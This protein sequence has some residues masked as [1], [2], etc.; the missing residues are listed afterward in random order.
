MIDELYGLGFVRK[1]KSEKPA[2]TKFHLVIG[3]FFTIFSEGTSGQQGKT[4]ADLPVGEAGV[5]QF[6]GDRGALVVQ[7]DDGGQAGGEVEGSK[8]SFWLNLAYR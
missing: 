3:L 6:R 4:Q 7:V 2:Q 5:D 1:Q 8:G